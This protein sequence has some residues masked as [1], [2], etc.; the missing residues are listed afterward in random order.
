MSRTTEPTFKVLLSHQEK[1][2]SLKP[3]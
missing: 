1:D 2:V 3:T